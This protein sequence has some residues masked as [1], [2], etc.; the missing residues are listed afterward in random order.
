MFEYFGDMKERWI[1]IVGILLFT[2]LVAYRAAVLPITHDEASTWLNF[3]HHNIWGCISDY[4]C[5]QTA[6]NHW[7][8]TLLLQWTAGLFGEGAFAIRLPNVL[9]GGLYFLAAS[10]FSWRYIKTPML[11]L[12]GFLLLCGNVYLLDFFSLARGYGLM[13]SGVIWSIYCLLRYIERFEFRWLLFSVVAMVLA[14]FSNFTALL[15]L[16]SIGLAWLGWMIG[17]KKFSLIGR[18]GLLWLT[19]GIVL[20]GLLYYPIRT[21]SGSGEFEWGAASITE[22]INDLLRNLLY[23]AQYF[24]E[25]SRAILFWIV[26][27]ALVLVL[28]ATLLSKQFNARAQLICLFSLL[29]FNLVGIVVLEYATGSQAPIG[30]KSIYLIPFIFA[31]LALGLNLIKWGN[32]TFVFGVVFCGSMFYH[33]LHTLDLTKCREWYYDA[34]YPELFS[35]IFPNASNP[36]SVQL[37][38]SWI[39]NPALTYYQKTKPLPLSGL[40]YQKTLVIDT[41]MQYYFVEQTDTVGMYQAGF[42]ANKKIGP[43]ALFKNEAISTASVR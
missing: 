29:V 18:H 28:L 17:H 30:R 13:V 34:Y 22:T 27:G 1:L 14:V 8:N 43:Y 4:Y 19:T 11:Q 36:D 23:G 33:T 40:V 21:L 41:T 3:R 5:W 15:A 25:G 10:L 7:L 9:A 37:G 35:T 39:F 6:N 38:S 32:L 20:L 24:G 2:L 12:A 42:V 16:L 31:P 26:I